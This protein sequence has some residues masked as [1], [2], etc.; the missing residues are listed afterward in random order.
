MTEVIVGCMAEWIQGHLAI[1]Q[2]IDLVEDS[3][4]FSH[5]LLLDDSYSQEMF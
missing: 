2:G 5:M 4:Q 1:P 3:N